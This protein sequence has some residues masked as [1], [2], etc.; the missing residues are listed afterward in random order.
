MKR[1][2]SLLVLL[3]IVGFSGC[4]EDEP[5]FVPKTNLAQSYIV[6][7]EFQYA[8]PA[9]KKGL[10]VT[11]FSKNATDFEKRAQTA[12]KA[13]MDLLKTKDLYEIIIKMNATNDIKKFN[14]MAYVAY[15]PH[16]KDTWGKETNHVWLVKASD[17]IVKN[18]HLIE[19]G[20]EYPIE[21][22]TVKKYLEK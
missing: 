2:M 18:G 7:K 11:I 21:Y 4:G 13:A 14:L 6:Q 1:F 15:T 3:L 20:K 9:D 12:V 22:I 5:S 8:T 16:K 19:N 17:N 10:E